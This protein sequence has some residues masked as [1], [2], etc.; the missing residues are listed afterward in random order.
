MFPGTNGLTTCNALKVMD[1]VTP[2]AF[3]EILAQGT[4]PI[5][6]RGLVSDWPA[7]QYGQQSDEELN[8]YL[9]QFYADATVNLFSGMP[10]IDGRFFY[11][12]DMTGFNFTRSREKLD[13]VLD[14]LTCHHNIAP[15]H[16][17]YVG[18]TT[19]D[20]CLP[21]FTAENTL[22]FGDIDPLVSI[23]IGN[24]TRIAAHYDLP[25]NLACVVAGHRR[26]TLFPPE[27]LVNLYVG[28][29]DFTP[30]GQQ[31]SLVDFHDPDLDRFPRFAQALE[32][33]LVVDMAPGDAIFIPSMWWHHVESLDNLNILLNYWWR[34][35]PGYMGPPVDVLL[36]ALLSLR[37]LPPEQK[38]AWAG[39]FDHYVF[40]ED[41]PLGHIPVASQGFLG[42][43][44]EKV[45]RKLRATLLAR[46]N[47]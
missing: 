25:D 18:A 31:I 13:K 8:A 38:K 39:I 46:L 44:D 2:G 47:R 37:D 24:R 14:Q 29:L 17:F 16:C 34:K 23:W 27:Q 10:E 9:R 35:S 3:A 26:F 22:E 41:T 45:A 5:L 36:H 30:A 11:N 43:M 15:S 21:G 6:L 32:H 19:A 4:E 1:D 20:N 42:P 7:V 40:S 12:E 28:P 33:A